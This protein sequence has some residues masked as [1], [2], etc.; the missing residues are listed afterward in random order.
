MPIY[1]S[2]CR[3]IRPALA[4]GL[5][6][7][8]A[9]GVVGAAPAV[10]Y[11]Q[12][13]VVGSSQNLTDV[14]K[15]FQ[16]IAG[17]WVESGVPQPRSLTI[18]GD[19]AYELVSQDGSKTFGKVLVTAEE[20]PDGSKSL[21]YSFFEDGGL[22]LEDGD[23]DSPWFSA[24]T[25]AGELW[26][27]FPKNPKAQTQVEL[28]SGQDGAMTFLRRPKEA[29]LTAD[30]RVNA[31]DYI[32]VWGCG[33]C[34]VVISQEGPKYLVEIQ[35]AGSAAEGSRWIYE[36]TYDNYSALLFSDAN[37]ER[38]DYTCGEDDVI[39]DT[40]V[41]ND[42][43]GSFILRDGVLTWWDAKEDAGQGLELVQTP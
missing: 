32:G 13:A 18:H 7:L 43:H 1:E 15:S 8:C 37:G 24:F 28:I 33:R 26:A 39:R 14:E 6:A 19:G 38:I 9:G 30:K 16:P 4:L 40:M 23:T 17:C 20:H 5:A 10:S 3:K 25:S 31:G 36:C 35:W 12:S 29:P 41:Y 2:L 22:T 27:A 42:G 11:A 21:W 34:S